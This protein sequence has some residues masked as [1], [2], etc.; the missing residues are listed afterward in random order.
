VTD[1]VRKETSPLSSLTAELRDGQLTEVGKARRRCGR[2]PWHKPIIVLG[3]V[4]LVNC[5]GREL[6][7]GRGDA[8]CGVADVTVTGR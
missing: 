8:E 3:G 6:C 4:C 7:P 5:P 1:V 2:I